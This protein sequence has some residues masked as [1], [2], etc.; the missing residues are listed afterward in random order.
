MSRLLK[1]RQARVELLGHIAALEEMRRG[2]LIRQFV[3]V[4]LKGH[5]NPFL[6]GPYPLFTYKKNG[7]TV[8][9]RVPHLDEVRKLELQVE[10]YHSFR[11]LCSQ[12]VD[13]S[14]EI[15]DEKERG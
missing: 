12:L 13:V 9:R 1:L 3:K 7:R 4:K 2:S 14:E 6:S 10:N 15:C 8:S 5:K 11:R